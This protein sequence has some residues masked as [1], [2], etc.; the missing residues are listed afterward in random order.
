MSPGSD[1]LRYVLMPPTTGVGLHGCNDPD[2]PSDGLPD[3]WDPV[4]ESDWD[5]DVSDDSDDDPEKDDPPKCAVCKGRG[6]IKLFRTDDPCKEC[7][8]SGY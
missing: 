8:G 4:E 3:V 2:L 1:R 5:P 6:K 7:G